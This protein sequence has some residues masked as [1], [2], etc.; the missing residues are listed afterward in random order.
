M[1]QQR[2]WELL[3]AK[4]NGAEALAVAGKFSHR[5]PSQEQEIARVLKNDGPQFEHITLGHRLSGKAN[6]PRR[7]VT[8]YLN[9]SVA[10][11]QARF[12]QM[13]E[14]LRSSQ[15]GKAIGEV[16]I[17]KADGVPRLCDSLN[18]QWRPFFGSSSQYM[19]PR[20]LVYR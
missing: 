20:P 9:S 1:I 2:C 12:V 17:L 14:D 5:N 8:A 10:K 4:R 13:V 18:D 11:H 3:A 15:Q 16:L 7:M 6:F 19:A